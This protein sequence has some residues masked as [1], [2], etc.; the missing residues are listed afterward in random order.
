MRF[1]VFLLGCYVLK[2]CFVFVFVFVTRYVFG[3]G[4]CRAVQGSE[5]KQPAHLRLCP[6]ALG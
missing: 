6:R 1:L 4:M 3:V 2:L 5:N